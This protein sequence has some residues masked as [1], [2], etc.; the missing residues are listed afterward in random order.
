M[1][2]F[3]ADNELALDAVQDFSFGSNEKENP[4]DID[5][6]EIANNI[7]VCA[8]EDQRAESYGYRWTWE[9]GE[10]Q[11]QE[12]RIKLNDFRRRKL[13]SFR[14][15]ACVSFPKLFSFPTLIKFANI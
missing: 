7:A 5:D 14:V 3:L 6:V 13:E 12:V 10:I 9:D 1:F 4:L 11:E 15:S 2:S 8:N